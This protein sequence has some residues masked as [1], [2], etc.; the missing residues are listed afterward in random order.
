MQQKLAVDMQ[1]AGN[2]GKHTNNKHNILILQ[3]TSIIKMIIV[4]MMFI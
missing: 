2:R 4:I 3:M 1:A